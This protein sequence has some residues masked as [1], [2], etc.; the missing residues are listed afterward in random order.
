MGFRGDLCPFFPLN[1]FRHYS[2]LIKTEAGVTLLRSYL[3]NER[4]ERMLRGMG[5][6]NA[7]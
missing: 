1:T 4:V 2:L 5:V 7:R 3:R 6:D